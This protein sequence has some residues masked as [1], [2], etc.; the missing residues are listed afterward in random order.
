MMVGFFIAEKGG[1]SRPNNLKES[2]H[3]GPLRAG[4][5]PGGSGAGVQLWVAR[6]LQVTICGELD[7]NNE[8]P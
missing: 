3:F 8:I 6:A 5:I 4:R 1:K 2:R 7:I